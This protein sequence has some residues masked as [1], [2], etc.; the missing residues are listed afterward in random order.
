MAETKMIAGYRVTAE[1]L[2]SRS[3]E[4]IA[5]ELARK[6]SR[7]FLKELD[8]TP[9][10]ANEEITVSLLRFPLPEVPKA[11]GHAEIPKL[12]DMVQCPE[13]LVKRKIEVT[14]ARGTGCPWCSGEVA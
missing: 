9:L 4:G 14:Y 11:E 10:Q 13:C 7:A 5:D 2:R 12:P 1:V 8:S 3:M 6:I